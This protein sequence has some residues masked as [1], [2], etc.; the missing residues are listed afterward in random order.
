MASPTQW[1][2][3]WAN[4]R[5]WWRTGGPGVLQTMGSQ[6]DRQNWATEQLQHNDPGSPCI[7]SASLLESSVSPRNLGSFAPRHQDLGA[8]FAHSYKSIITFSAD[9]EKKKNIHTKPRIYISIYIYISVVIIC[10]QINLHTSSFWYLHSYYPWMILAFSLCVSVM[11]YS[12]YWL[13]QL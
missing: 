6:R 9:R 3:V 4:S 5:R 10:I 11:S 1:I 7:F 13:S 12:L 2:W 8:R